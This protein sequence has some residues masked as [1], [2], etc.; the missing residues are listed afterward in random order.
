MCIIMW[1]RGH[2]SLCKCSKKDGRQRYLTSYYPI[3]A[4][5]HV[6]LFCDIS[7]KL[8]VDKKGN[9]FRYIALWKCANPNVFTVNWLP[10][11]PNA[12]KVQTH[13]TI[14]SCL[15]PVP[16]VVKKF[17][18]GYHSTMITSMVTCHMDCST[19]WHNREAV[20]QSG[21]L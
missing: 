3:H 11:M 8:L 7:I 6:H 10:C 5:F 9:A 18:P 19:T 16:P 13:N 20:R 15:G 4:K 1:L 2:M 17:S 14:I 12:E 21:V